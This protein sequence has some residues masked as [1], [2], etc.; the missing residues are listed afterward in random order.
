MRSKPGPAPGGFAPA[1]AQYPAQ[2]GYPSAA[3]YFPPQVFLNWILI[4]FYFQ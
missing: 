1:A 4:A 3:G 2:P